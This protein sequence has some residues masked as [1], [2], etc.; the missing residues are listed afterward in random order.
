ML[1]ALATENAML[2]AG[3]DAA[4]IGLCIVDQNGLIVQ[5]TEHFARSLGAKV[6][7]HLGL[8]AETLRLPQLK[9]KPFDQVFSVWSSEFACEAVVTP[10]RGARQV[11]IF[12]GRTFSQDAQSF[13]VITVLNIGEFGISRSRLIDL[14]RQL[15]AVKASVV[16]VDAQQP[17]LPIVYA[18][19]QFVEVT[20][21]ALADIIGRNCRFLQGDDTEAEGLAQ[22]RMALKLQRTCSVVL[23][24]YRKNG[25]RFLNHLTITPLTDGHGRVSHYVAIQRVV[26]DR[27][28]L[29]A[30]QG[31]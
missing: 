23:T 5:M 4:R 24:N 21:Y 12:Q 13:R 15:D 16:L 28:A 20:G 11:V 9:L 26:T 10:E 6:D 1:N 27:S 25:L 3:L 18:N 22:I 8:S 7:A 19:E 31:D 2:R 30:G 29:D 14:R 17:D